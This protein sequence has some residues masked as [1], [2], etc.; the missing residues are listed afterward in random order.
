MN[1]FVIIPTLHEADPILTT[2]A[3]VTSEAG[4]A[5]IIYSP[6]G[7]HRLHVALTLLWPPA[8][9][10]RLSPHDFGAAF[11]GTGHGPARSVECRVGQLVV[12][13]RQ[14]PR[15]GKVVRCA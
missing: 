11:C 8:A 3:S 6:A 1:I 15:I 12:A 9:N 5:E 10:S 13:G 4:V 2:L 14:T 7:R